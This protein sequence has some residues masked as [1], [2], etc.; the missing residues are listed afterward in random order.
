MNIKT[1]ED[2]KRT[3]DLLRDTSRYR[4]VNYYGSYRQ[5]KLIGVMA[6]YDFRMNLF[7]RQ[8][9]CGGIGLVAVDLLYKKEQICKDMVYFFIEH[10]KN[11]KT[12]MTALYPF[13]PDFYRK[14]GF[15]IGSKVQQYS[16]NPRDLVC[17]KRKTH[18][19]R[20]R[21]KDEKELEDCYNRYARKHH[22]MLSERPNKWKR[23]LN[24]PGII[25]MGY[26]KSNKVYGYVVFNFKKA[27]GDNWIKNNIIIREFI[28][29]DREAFHELLYFLYTQYDQIDRI[30]YPT[31]DDHFHF[32]LNDPR[33][34]SENILAVLAHQTNT[35]GIGIMYRVIDMARLFGLL[36]KHDFN[37][38][39]CKI[40]IDIKDSLFKRNQKSI[41]L[42]IEK[43]FIKS[44][45]KREY[46][47]SI[48]LDVADFS[49][50][51]MGAVTFQ[52]LYDYGL[53]QISASR[54]IRLVDNLFSVKEKPMC[55]TQF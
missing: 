53:A 42:H 36:K 8:I 26:K 4:T 22:G 20:M 10:Y 25:C 6:L 32:M 15:G 18:V 33:D 5:D 1:A 52:S 46:D 55:T 34:D 2:K 30:I 27:R 21:S 23:T 48:Q 49:S 31:H 12:S 37:G 47:V 14:M 16:I 39:S 44:S 54:Y 43:G 35:Q 51:I 28:C 17:E 29:E 7:G 24:A 11:K 41:V 19:L 9:P 13:R 50:L 45:C 3:L 40:K 38:Q